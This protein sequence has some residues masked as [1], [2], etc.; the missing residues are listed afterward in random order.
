MDARDF[1]VVVPYYN[2]AA[3]MW[4]TLAALAAQSDTGFS[5]V[6]IDNASTDGGAEVAARFAAA[7]PWLPVHLIHEPC[8]GTGAAADTGFR[9]AIILGARYIARTDADCVP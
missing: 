7:H 9:H 8:K 2:E 1:F 5:L 4:P 3:G 6:L